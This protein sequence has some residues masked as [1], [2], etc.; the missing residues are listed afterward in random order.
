MVVDL[1]GGGTAPGTPI[2]AFQS[3]NGP[4]QVWRL[5]EVA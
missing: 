5:E 1:Y 3:W 4:N 2:I